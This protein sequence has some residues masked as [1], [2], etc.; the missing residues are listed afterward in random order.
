MSYNH[1]I[2]NVFQGLAC[3]SSNLRATRIDST[4]P[5]KMHLRACSLKM[6]QD[7]EDECFRFL[8]GVSSLPSL[9]TLGKTMACRQLIEVFNFKWFHS[10]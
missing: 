1:I 3:S 5:C 7:I 10:I 4:A 9:A 6:A 2:V 8:H